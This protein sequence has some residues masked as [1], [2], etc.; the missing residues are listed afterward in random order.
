MALN[1]NVL[2]QEIVDTITT[3]GTSQAER[4]A[5]LNSWRL[6]A[7]AIV[8]HF[9]NNAELDEAKLEQGLNTIFSSGVPVPQD[10]GSALKVAWTNATAGGAKDAVIGGI[11]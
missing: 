10:G 1:G 9:K 7:N 8:N 3:D 5:L 4:D 6:I 2:A 11:K